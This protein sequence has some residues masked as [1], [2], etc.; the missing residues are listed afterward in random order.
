MSDRKQF[1]TLT[2]PDELHDTVAGLDIDPGTETV[3][4]AEARGRVLGE[5]LDAPLDVPGFDRASVDGYALR[6][7]ETAGASETTPVS[8]SVVGTV[9]AGEEPDVSVGAGE[10]VQIS[11]GAVVPSGA[12]AVVMVEQTSEGDDGRLVQ[13][14]L[15]PGSGI[16]PAGADIAA[17]ER[18][19]PAGTRLTARETGLLAALGVDSVPVRA[20][21]TVGII[22]TGDELVPVGESLD[23]GAGQIHDV[24]TPTIAAAVASA[25]GEPKRYPHVGDDFDAMADLL[26]RASAECDLVL[27]SGSTSASA[28]D[29]V[30]RVIEETGEL[31]VH[32]VAVKPGKPLLVGELGDGAYVGLPG[33]PVSALTTFRVFVAPAI[34]EA[35]GLPEP[36]RATLTG[37]L[38]VEERFEPGRLRYVPVG[39]T[40]DGDGDELVYPVD[41][42]SG[43]TTSLTDADGVV[44]MAPETQ[45]LA[46]GESVTVELFSPDVRPP[47]LL[48][49]G[50]SGPGVSRL[51]DAASPDRGRPPRYLSRGEQ[52]ARSWLADDVPDFLVTS[53]DATG[54]ETLGAWT[55]EW[56]LIVPSGNPADVTGIES[57]DDDL[58][59]V[60]QASGTGLDAA[61]GTLADDVPAGTTGPGIESPARQVA[62]GR[63]DVGVGLRATADRLGLD[64]VSLGTQRLRVVVNPTRTEKSAVARLEAALDS[65]SFEGLAGYER[66]DAPNS[67]SKSE[68]R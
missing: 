8:L 27:S 12:D 28:V 14:A 6:A 57:L 42:G 4:L 19:L 18:A 3:P 54:G 32:G 24:N 68:T 62:G 59:L 29:V 30:Y 40:T 52:V 13:T 50:A 49:M 56:G 43:A 48:G 17:G 53:D 61:F 5:R 67:S 25:G 44:A 51:L 21:P 60:R 20:R 31:L 22:S 15:T 16:M 58:R 65:L 47:A 33:Y 41:K 7:S 45:Y 23:S 63:A 11:T 66:V 9:H 34:R 37:E 1:R 38:A 39:V 2:P 36:E 64:V 35:A 26:E 55:R 46:A 10:C